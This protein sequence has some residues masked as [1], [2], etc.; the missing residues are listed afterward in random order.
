MEGGYSNHPVCMLLPLDLREYKILLSRQAFDGQNY[1][2][3]V[4]GKIWTF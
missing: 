2:D 3:F 4:I 1:K